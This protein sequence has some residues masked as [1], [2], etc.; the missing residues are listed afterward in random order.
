MKDS[1]INQL[2]ALG[3]GVLAEVER[4][5]LTWG[6]LHEW[7]PSEYK[8]RLRNISTDDLVQ[9]TR[10]LVLLDTDRRYASGSVAPAIWVFKSLEDRQYSGLLALAEWIDQVNDNSY[11]PFGTQRYRSECFAKL[12]DV[13]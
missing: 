11:L 12:R 1:T 9:L 6:E 5:S 7:Q 8:E 4:I 10:S 3:D 2:I 13:D